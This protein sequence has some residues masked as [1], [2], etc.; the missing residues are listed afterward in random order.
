MKFS[1]HARRALSWG[2]IALSLIAI[3][4]VWAHS[5]GQVQTTKFFAPETVQLLEDRISAGQPGGFLVGDV[6]TYII[7]FTPVEN[8]ASVGVAGYITDYLPP[9]VEVVGA[10]FVERGANDTYFAVPPKLPGGIDFGWGN[11]GP[12]N[13][14]DAPFDTAAYDLTG[15]CLAG[16]F[17]TGNCDARMHE[18][19]ADTGIFYSTDSRTAAFPA[20]PLRIAQ[21][22]NGYNI[23]P[24]AAGQLNP[25]IGQTAATTH[26]LWD[27][28]Q[29]NAFGSG[30][31][32]NIDDLAQ[33]K[34]SAKYL[35]NGGRGPTPYR[36]GSAVAGPQTG[37]SLDNTAQVGPWQRIAYPGSRI[38]DPTTGPA[39]V[40]GLSETA[41]GGLPTS[42]GYNLS[43][44]NPLPSGTN[45]VRWAAGKLTVG[46][47]NY[48]RIKLRVTQPIPN[49]GLVNS[50]EVFGGDAGDSGGTGSNS[51]QDNVWRYHVPSVADNNSNLYVRKIPCVYDPTATTCVP[52]TSGYY[53]A[54]STV[55]YQITYINTGNANQTNVVLRDYLPCQT[56][57][58]ATTLRVGA[59]SGPLAA[60]AP[61]TSLPYTTN[62]TANGNCTAPQT[63]HTVTFPT[64]ASLGPGGGGKMVV[65]VRN[66]AGTVGDVVVNTA[67]LASTAL[68]LGV[69]SNAITF[70]GN[71]SNPVLSIAK[72]NAVATTTAGGTT[73][74][75]IVVRN[76]GTGPA[77]ALT[78][79]DVLPTM[80]GSANPA[81]RFNYVSTVS[82]SSTGLTTDTALV[83]STN[84]SALFTPVIP[85]YNTAADA[86][87]A[88]QVRWG[89]GANSSLAV[90]G[91][92]TI[93]FTVN[94]GTSVAATP[95]P[96]LNN[97]TVISGANFL[98]PIYRADAAGVAGIT[99]V[100]PLSVSKTLDCYFVGATCIAANGSNTVPPNSRVRYRVDYANTGAV[101]LSS[102]VLTD[103]LPCQIS[104]TLA[105][106]ATVTAVASG[107]I[108]PT[109][110]TPY[111]L[112]TASGNCPA[113]RPSFSF[114][115]ASLPAGQTGSLSIDVQLTTPNGTSNVVVNDVSLS[116]GTTQASAQSQATVLAEARLLISKTASTSAVVPGGTL[117]YTITLTNVGTTAAQTVTVYDWL[118]TGTSTVADITRRFSYNT[119]TSVVTG[120]L[121]AVAPLN[122]TPT[123]TPYASGTYAANQE[124][125]VWNFGVQTLPV[126]GSA[127]ITFV[128]RVGSNLPALPPPNYYNNYARVTYH[129]GQQA[130]SNAA[131][132]SVSLI[133]NLTIAKSNGTTTLTA[134]SATRY[135]VTVANLG[136]SAAGGA[137]V[138]DT[139]GA[140][141]LCTA[142][143][144]AATTGAATCPAALSLGS[145]V[146]VGSTAFFSTG[147]VIPS[148]PANSS[149]VF[150]V[151]CGVL[152]TGL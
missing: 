83:T 79:A 82:I 91:A 22:T 95:T 145:P 111:A 67:N 44:S 28:D 17:T 124:Q 13:G 25:I 51:G 110:T 65:N 121:T 6:I 86:A 50:S 58:G 84:T 152:A 63:R 49:D 150:T 16:G 9:G 113:T 120:N 39:D 7:Q 136:P 104:A 48:V 14:F 115:V 93:T 98:D 80:G 102:V 114:P 56:T 45:A 73:Q 12:V 33:P 32:A 31:Q 148:L 77:D 37:Y 72:T 52:L 112:Q 134:G 99:V 40:Q 30:S 100:S 126:G 130:N 5:V 128:A 149:V 116:S 27:A 131:S 70:V 88:L 105:A 125:L 2:A 69:N 108:A 143:T 29:T 89:F 122:S 61:L 41:V 139:A 106:E 138:K 103:T 23:I 137:V 57:T 10:D 94:V 96:Y 90:G 92:I 140:G 109:T 42:L 68:P 54:S 66:T 35:G 135:T 18:L 38:G 46:Q 34:S 101:A 144:C 78:I 8:N 3:Q 71:A 107:P 127:A 74:Y 81:T 132:A 142:V 59:V 119:T 97:A 147:E 87:N 4:R 85:P 36:A 75:T 118:P 141:L 11:Q 146:G 24:T 19:H 133:A 123:L 117:S 43:P 20:L 60:L 62:T 76:T 129:N 64:I 1:R 47:I 151:D 15:R 55:T 21:G 53:A 26:N